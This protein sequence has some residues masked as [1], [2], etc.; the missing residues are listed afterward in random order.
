MYGFIALPPRFQARRIGLNGKCRQGPRLGDARRGQVAKII[1]ALIIPGG[2]QYRRSFF[3]L[4]SPIRNHTIAVYMA[5]TTKYWTDVVLKNWNARRRVKAIIIAIVAIVGAILFW[6]IA[7]PDR[8][9][10]G[11]ALIKRG[12]NAVA[13]KTVKATQEQPPNEQSMQVV[14]QPGA[15]APEPYKVVV[16]EKTALQAKLSRATNQLERLGVEF[17]ESERKATQLSKELEEAKATLGKAMRELQPVKDE[18]YKLSLQVNELKKTLDASVLTR[19]KIQA[20]VQELARVEFGKAFP[21]EGGAIEGYNVILR[22]LKK[23]LP[24]DSFVQNS[25]ELDVNIEWGI[26]AP[27]LGNTSSQLRGY[28]DTTYLK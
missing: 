6:Y 15:V 8:F 27:M 9:D 25:K 18:N 24:N 19:K 22:S 1:T 7:F 5:G 20:F 14:R 3:P 21:R 16:A 23:E 13:W 12:I 26:L 10:R 4:I 11:A 17:K 28:L 2:V